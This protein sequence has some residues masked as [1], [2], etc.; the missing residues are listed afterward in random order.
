MKF[1]WYKASRFDKFLSMPRKIHDLI[2]DLKQAGFHLVPGGKGSHRKYRH[3]QLDGA[4]ILSGG[5]NEDARYYQ[6]K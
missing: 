5:D 4:I 1:E 2:S 3:S 6:E